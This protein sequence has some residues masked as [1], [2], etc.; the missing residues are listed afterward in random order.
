MSTWIGTGRSEVGLVRSSNQDAYLLLDR[1]GLWA[2]AD[3]MGGHVGGDVAAET[4]ITTIKAHALKAADVIRT[5]QQDAPSAFLADLIQHAHEAILERARLDSSLKGMGTTIVLLFI[6]PQPTPIAHVAHLGDSRAY[7]FRSGVLTPL[8]RDHTLIEKYL[9]RGILTPKTA[10]THPERH[11]L[12]QAL[13]VSSSV[14]PS[15][16]SCPL[17][18]NDL[19]LLCS[20][21]LTKMLDDEQIRDICWKAHS[22]PIKTCDSL[23]AASLDR[24]GTDNVTVLVIGHV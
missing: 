12:T 5:E 8:T 21:G 6:R 2:V 17:E 22:D 11:V 15:F 13:G 20:D 24:G 10:R 7:L 18:Q 19:L 4:A 3:G 14:K 9:E 16:S 1:L 23:I